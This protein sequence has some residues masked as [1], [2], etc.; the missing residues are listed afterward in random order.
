[1]LL[2]LPAR[3]PGGAA[4]VC[5][6]GAYKALTLDLAEREGL[7]LPPLGDADSPGLRAA[8]PDFVPV[9]NPLDVTAQGLVDPGLYARV[10]AALVA[11]ERIESVLLAIIQTDAVTAK[12]KFPP[13]L[14]AIE[15]LR[16]TKRVRL[17]WP[18]RRRRRPAR[19]CRSPARAQRPLFSILGARRPRARACC[20]LERRGFR[21]PHAAT[22][23]HR[24]VRRPCGRDPG[25]AR[26]A[27]PGLDR[28]SVSARRA[29]DH[30]RGGRGDRDKDRLSAS[31]SR[32]SP[33]SLRTRAMLAA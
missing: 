30:V 17:R 28:H 15:E 13:I 27:R 6:S 11:D 26:Q 9:S 8:L 19:L 2:R 32:R 4:V 7:P 14:A 22:S 16:P 10:L 3:T 21:F 1:M 33:R 18:G 20:A 29:S 24:D 23:Q 12:L 31:S 25:M 5:E